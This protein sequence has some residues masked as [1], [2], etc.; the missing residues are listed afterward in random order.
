MNSAKKKSN[1]CYI[2]R[3][4]FLVLI[5]VVISL[6]VGVAV[7]FYFV[8]NED[9][10]R[11]CHGEVNV[12]NT[13]CP[14][15]PDVP[16]PS[17]PVDLG[18][19]AGRLSSD[20]VPNHYVVRTQLYLDNVDGP[21]Q[22]TYDGEV[23]I[24]MH[25]FVTTSTIKL[26]FREMTIHYGDTYVRD[27]Q[28]N[29]IVISNQYEDEEYEFVVIETATP[30]QAGEDYTIY[31]KYDGPLNFDMHGM[32]RSFY[33]TQPFATDLVA[34]Q[35]QAVAARKAFPCYDEPNFKATFDIIIVHRD[36]RHALS[37]MP[38][39]QETYLEDDWL[40][41]TFDTTV[42]MP[43]YL[44][45]ILVSDFPYLEIV[46]NGFTFRVWAQPDLIGA[47]NYSLQ[48]GFQMLRFFE[49]YY[50]ISY[51]ISKMDFVAVP[52]FASGA[53]EN[54]GL[55]LYTE[56]A[57]LYDE[58]ENTPARKRIVASYVA[59]ELAHKWFGNLVTLDWWDHLWLNE[60][61]A[62]FVTYV[63]MDH[64]EPS[65]QIWESF[66]FLDMANAYSA[67]STTLTSRPII[68]EVGWNAEINREFDS[69]V[70]NKGAALVRHFRSFLDESVVHQGIRDYLNMYLYDNVVTDDL[71][72]VLTEADK[73][74][75]GTNVK[76]IMDSWT[77]QA[78]HP[79][80]NIT[81]TGT[82][83]VVATQTYFMLDP[84]EYY[85]DK[86]PNNGYI[87]YVPLTYTDSTSPD[88]LKP[89]KA[90]LYKDPLQL[91]LV[92][93]GD[94]DW[95]LFNI[96]K[97]GFYRVNYDDD[98]WQKL[99]TQLKTDHTVIS[100]Q[101]RA[102]MI[103]DA[104][105]VSQPFHTDNVNALRLTEYMDKEFSYVVWETVLLNLGYTHD[106]LLRTSEFYMFEL[107]W[108]VQVTPL[109]ES[110]GWDFS[111]G[112]DVDYFQRIN[113]IVTACNYG[114]EDCVSEAL[115]QYRAWMSTGEND[116]RNEVRAA[117]YC[118]AVRHGG[119]DEWEFAYDE[120]LSPGAPGPEAALETNRL[121]SAMGCTEKTWLLQ[122]YLEDDNFDIATVISNTRDKSAVGYSLAWDYAMNNFDTL[123]LSYDT[124]WDFQNFMNTQYDLDQLN[125][126]GSRHFDMPSSDASGFY[127]AV[128]RVETNIAWMNRNKDSMKEWLL[129]VTA[130]M[131]TSAKET[132]A[133][134]PRPN[135]NS[136][137]LYD[138]GALIQDGKYEGKRVPRTSEYLYQLV[139]SHHG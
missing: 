29:D 80:V 65:W 15:M 63:G 55:V 115:R 87:W 31:V 97:W 75:K 66:H 30:L 137:R 106:M 25:C 44:L 34:T 133:D 42:L 107:Y 114:N 23:T 41:T 4:T 76:A 109:Y 54:W 71:W 89:N 59:H 14:P 130:T 28:Q 138:K 112:D 26:H 70:Y 128:E 91:D 24:S 40:E 39:I 8:P 132:K 19:F 119:L 105:K 21:N 93:V 104:F 67:D 102:S 79:V 116:I 50:G 134:I 99:A 27:S 125:V 56:N 12:A 78:G 103:D 101:S 36:R 51:P 135:P 48:I 47:A 113:A 84:N 33:G 1:A 64:V 96:D 11:D 53:M 57:M 108:S 92:G 60:G 110:L 68:Q 10:G 58:N 52:Q 38:V 6:L 5:F 94:N 122:R 22:Y 85:D 46:D 32:Y 2:S 126:F 86:H 117:V 43:T 121:L 98:N 111:L 95:V 17:P 37:N 49:D 127:D 120:A 61:F 83:T 88:F 72:E 7:L 13:E 136:P 35:Y 81:R 69:I 129:E 123:G 20:I 16:D 9:E 82:S 77:L 90:L 3:T 73:D 131:T 100:N 74:F 118:T 139:A 124:I 45:A 62:S 18:P